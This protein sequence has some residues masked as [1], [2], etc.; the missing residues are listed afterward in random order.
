MVLEN[1]EV[2]EIEP[3]YFYDFTLEDIK[4]KISR[5]AVNCI[6]VS[7]TAYKVLMSIN[8]K[9]DRINKPFGIET[10][11]PDTIFERLKNYNDITG[12]SLTYEDDTEE[13]YYV[14]Y[15][16]GKREGEIGAPNINQDSYI[17]E[18]GHL[19]ITICSEKKVDD[20]FPDD[21]L[22]EDIG[23]WTLYN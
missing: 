3:K 10:P 23:H 8:K 9:A 14:N 19:F 6:G 22:K 17:N 21:E 5:K 16:E 11:E 12:I 7:K 20:L 2:I 4:E 1:C 15:D 13:T 18:Y